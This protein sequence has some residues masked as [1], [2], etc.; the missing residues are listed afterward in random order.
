M[1]IREG[2]LGPVGAGAAEIALSRDRA[3]IE[4]SNERFDRVAFAERAIALVRPERTT[5]AICAGARQLRVESGRQWGRPGERWAMLA[6][7]ARASRRAIALAVAELADG[8]S[9]ER[10]W[11][12]DVLLGDAEAAHPIA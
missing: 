9:A 2:T 10:A 3:M 8:A 5:V 4:T 11:V 1:T 6:I 12:Y 7:P